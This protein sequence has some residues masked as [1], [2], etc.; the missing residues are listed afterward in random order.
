MYRKIEGDLRMTLNEASERFPDSFILIRRDNRD[1]FNPM[2]TVLYI[3][4]DYHELFSMQVD[5]DDSLGI[6][7]DGLNHHR[8]LGGIEIRVRGSI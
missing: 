3:G 1:L 6:V 4:D 8:S 7:V 5:M 2:G